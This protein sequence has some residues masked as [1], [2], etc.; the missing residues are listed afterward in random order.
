MADEGVRPR[1]DHLVIAIGLDP[2]RRFEM[3]V[4]ALGPGCAHEACDQR[5]VSN[6]RHPVRRDRPP[7]A[8]V[9]PGDGKDEREKDDGDSCNDRIHPF[10]PFWYFWRTLMSSGLSRLIQLIATKIST[11]KS[12]R[13]S[14]ARRQSIVPAGQNRSTVITSSVITM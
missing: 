6:Q 3:P 4:Y 12:D 8:L 11:M 5:G 1:V 9:Q 14:Q 10:V 7:E 13:K 2:N